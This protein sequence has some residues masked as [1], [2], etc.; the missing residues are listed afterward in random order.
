[1]GPRS[2][3]D[4]YQHGEQLGT[5]GANAVTITYYL[6]PEIH[7]V[8]LCNTPISC[9]S[10]FGRSLFRA[11]QLLSFILTRVKITKAYELW[12][13]FG[14]NLLASPTLHRKSRTSKKLIFYYCPFYTRS[15]GPWNLG[16]TLS[17]FGLL[18]GPKL[19]INKC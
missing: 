17:T 16:P 9:A 10:I 6:F 13:Q 1:M 5:L 7:T 4:T 2:K 3:T 12:R 11:C 8:Q 14:S 15:P 18:F 19:L